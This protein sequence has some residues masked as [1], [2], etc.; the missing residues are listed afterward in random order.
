M[1]NL[2]LFFFILTQSICF[3]QEA[4]NDSLYGYEFST[5]VVNE[6]DDV[7]QRM[8]TLNSNTIA[9]NLNY[10]DAIINSENYSIVFYE[11]EN[12]LVITH[13]KTDKQSYHFLTFTT[14]VK[15]DNF[16]TKHFT[17]ENGDYFNL[18]YLVKENGK[19]KFG[20]LEILG[21]ENNS[22]NITYFIN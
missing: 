22:K 8:D 15:V 19:N 13:N 11:F 18:R 20:A 17:D 4:T 16:I 10:P 2:I 21:L 9:F 7:S 1:K 12:L 3:S 14:E 6:I 5:L